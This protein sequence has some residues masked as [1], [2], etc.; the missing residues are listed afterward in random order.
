MLAEGTDEEGWTAIWILVKP[1]KDPP[2]IRGVVVARDG[3]EIT[4]ETD[5][6]D[7]KT[8]TLPAHARGVAHGEVVTVFEGDE[9]KAKGLV[10][11]EE[12]KDRLEKFRD[13]AGEG[14]DEPEGDVDGKG[15]NHDKAAA[16][17]AR[18][19]RFLARFN[20]RQTQLIDGV[21][22][23]ASERV[24]AKLVL[25]KERIHAQRLAHQETIGRIWAKLDRQHPAHSHRGG[26][27]AFDENRPDNSDRG[28]RPEGAGQ[29]GED[30]TAGEGSERGR[31]KGK[32]GG[33][34]PPT[35]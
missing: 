2:T 9:G 24:K 32:G 13:A 35:P 33:T 6:G 3:D 8:V 34:E 29:V 5:N 19:D 26:A 12:V 17:I 18:I 28:G 21:I 14:V 27:Q 20:E 16:R 23:G 1:V 7:K 22:G 31:G 4:I 15:K 11:A 10:R 25:V 30:P